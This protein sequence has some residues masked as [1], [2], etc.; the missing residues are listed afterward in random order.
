MPCMNY[1]RNF[2]RVLSPRCSRC[3]YGN[4]T[5]IL[6]S[7][8]ANLINAREHCTLLLL[9]WGNVIILFGYQR[10]AWGCDLRL[11]T[12]AYLFKTPPPPSTVWKPLLPSSTSTVI[13]S[14]KI[15]KIRCFS[16]IFFFY[17][18]LGNIRWWKLHSTFSHRN[19][20]MVLGACSKQK[21]F[22]RNRYFLS[23]FVVKLVIT[24]IPLLLLSNQKLRQ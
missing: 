15:G 4:G 11:C 21:Y 19:N 7:L 3:F 13:R 1:G 14:V 5:Q 23:A 24:I 17:S 18:L 6:E 2:W 8:R 12:L 16:H 22:R 10:T 9:K 20:V